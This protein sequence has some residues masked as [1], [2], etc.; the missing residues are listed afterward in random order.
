LNAAFLAPR[1]YASRLQLLTGHS[2][3]WG[4][5]KG[6]ATAKTRKIIAQE[7]AR[8][9]A[10]QAV[11]YTLAALLLGSSGAD[12]DDG[13]VWDPRST[14]FGKIK[15]G[16]TKVDPWAGV[17][18]F[19]IFLSRIATGEKVDAK[20]KVV[21]LRGKN[22]KFGKDDMDKTI[23][24][25]LESKQSPNMALLHDIIR[26]KHY[27]GKELTGQTLAE[28]VLSP[29]SAR[30]TFEVLKEHGFP[31]GTALTFLL[32]LGEG[33]QTQQDDKKK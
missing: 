18:Q 20:G 12:D 15:V 25:F 7:Y 27:G 16:N 29:L 32:L 22:V 11:Y 13:I 23:V 24:R 19:A 26:Q 2:F 6:T 9:I 5:G 21:P 3:L 33:V 31:T 1:F 8:A 4:T 10:G 30:D 28:Q 17:A 14:D